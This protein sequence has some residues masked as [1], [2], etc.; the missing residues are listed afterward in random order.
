M[1]ERIFI[2][3]LEIHNEIEIHSL[4]LLIYSPADSLLM[5]FYIF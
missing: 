1:F 4:A 3:I 5:G 2:R